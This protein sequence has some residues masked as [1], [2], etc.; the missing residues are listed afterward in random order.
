MKDFHN[1]FMLPIILRGRDSVR[2]DD[3]RFDPGGSM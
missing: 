2:L 3:P 1:L